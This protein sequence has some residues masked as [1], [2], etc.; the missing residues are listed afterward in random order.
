MKP[1]VV[2]V[3]RLARGKAGYQRNKYKFGWSFYPEQHTIASLIHLAAVEGYSFLAGHFDR[4][5]P[6]FYGRADV[7]TPRISEN[8]IETKIIPLDDDGKAGN[9]LDFWPNDSLFGMFGAGYY[10]S[11]SSTPAAPRIRPI[12]ELD[13]PI[14][15]RESYQLARYALGWYYNRDVNRIDV[16]PQIPQVWYGSATPTEYKILGNVLPLEVLNAVV[17]DPYCRVK[18]AQDDA[19]HARRELARTYTTLD[20]LIRWLARQDHNRHNRLLALGYRA[21][22]AGV[23]WPDVA[24]GVIDACRQNGYFDEYAHSEREIE[25]VFLDGYRRVPR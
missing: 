5:P 6:E 17:I 8:F 14:T 3:S 15:G 25:R 1:F 19:R 13:Q 9:P 22:E 2:S 21:A 20:G 10:H 4:K 12:F 23:N 16:L 18:A 11:S 24:P 7:S